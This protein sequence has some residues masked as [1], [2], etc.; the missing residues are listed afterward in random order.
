MILGY[1][2]RLIASMLCPSYHLPG[3]FAQER[4][5]SEVHPG[6]APFGWVRLNFSSRLPGVLE[7][8]LA[9]HYS[10]PQ[11]HSLL[12]HRSHQPLRLG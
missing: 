9:A 3:A 10:R 6:R 5:G 8:L 1:S 4:L 7:A 12:Q 2:R 11:F